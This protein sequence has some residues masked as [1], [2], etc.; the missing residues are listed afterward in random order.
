MS[1][2]PCSNKNTRFTA[3]FSVAYLG[4]F[5]TTT[6]TTT[7]TSTTTTTTTT[8]STT[9]TTTTTTTTKTEAK[10]PVYTMSRKDEIEMDAYK[11]VFPSF[12][13][14]EHL[15]KVETK[16]SGIYKNSFLVATTIF[17]HFVHSINFKNVL[18][19][20]RLCIFRD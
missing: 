5:V 17:V 1:P 3:T 8:T 20:V 18:Y 6:T 15:E 11:Y 9:T 10:V 13:Y 4:D 2:G 7:T 12:R 19:I 16:L 14:F